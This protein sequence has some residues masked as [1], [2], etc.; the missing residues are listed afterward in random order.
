M[1]IDSLSSKPHME[2]PPPEVPEVLPELPETPEEEPRYYA[3]KAGQAVEVAPTKPSQADANAGVHAVPAFP[4]P[5]HAPASTPAVA[6]DN[7]DNLPAA[8]EDADIIEKE[9]VIKAKQLVDATKDD[10]HRQ[11]KEINKMKAAY[12]KK[13]YDKELKINKEG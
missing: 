5:V 8:A 12:I 4:P 10:P 6:S 13:R 11:N 1:S 2:L 3:E 9:W 7:D